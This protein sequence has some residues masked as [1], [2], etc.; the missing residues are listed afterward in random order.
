[1]HASRLIPALG[2][3]C[4]DRCGGAIGV[5]EAH[6]QSGAEDQFISPPAPLGLDPNATYVSLIRYDSSLGIGD[7]ARL[8][9]DASLTFGLEK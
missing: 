9:T 8:W 5:F 7:N 2:A 6:R 3:L 1:M 4:R